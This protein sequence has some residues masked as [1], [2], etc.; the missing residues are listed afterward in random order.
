[1]KQ[2]IETGD[3]RES[4]MSFRSVVDVAPVML[5][6]S[7]TDARCAF[8]NKAWLDFTGLSLKQQMEHDWVLGVHREDRERCVNMYLSA[9]KLRATF[10][11]EYRLLRNDG[12]YRWVFHH[13]V[14]RYAADGTFLGYVGSR[15]DFTDQRE[16]EEDLRE[17]TNQLLNEQEIE[18]SRIGHELGEEVAQKLC[19]V[20]VALCGFSHKYNR[21][22]ELQADLEK[23]QELLRDVSRD[24]IRLSHRLRPA[25]VQALALS[26]ALRNLCHQATDADRTVLFVQS[27]DMPPLPE[28][29]SVTLYRIAQE[30]LQNA[31]RHSRATH[32]NVELSASA[33]RVRL[34][35][36]DNGCGFVVGLN[37]KPA[38]GIS[39]M[40]ERMRSSGGVFNIVSSPNEGTTVIA[41]M[42][43]TQPMKLASTA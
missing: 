29:R 10:T 39:G 21:N 15:V 19:A 26:A 31:L 41:T 36:R 35:V 32:I 6:M 1:M 11:L 8:F 24:V 2:T 42:P 43:L 17:V 5:W 23:L 40:S 22:G 38:L 16:A 9:F 13:G 34:L 4:E 3:P 30:S 12:V 28:Y 18:R 33:Q 27:G 20:S 14:P 7:G 25:P 37:K